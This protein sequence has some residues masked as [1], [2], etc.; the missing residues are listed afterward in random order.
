MNK[1]I[2]YVCIYIYIYIHIYI[3]IYI[4]MCMHICVYI[5]IYIYTHT[6]VTEGFFQGMVPAE[7][8]RTNLSHATFAIGRVS[9]GCYNIL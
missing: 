8:Q 5:Y 6:E 9:V 4:H 2:M 7:P 3:Y 1:Y